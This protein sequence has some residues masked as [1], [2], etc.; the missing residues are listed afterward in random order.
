MTGRSIVLYI[1]TDRRVGPEVVEVPFGIVGIRCIAR[2][3]Q[4]QKRIVIVA[5]EGLVVH[6]PES[7]Q[8]H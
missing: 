4:E 7:S 6:E 2:L 1:G 3:S 8:W 5:A